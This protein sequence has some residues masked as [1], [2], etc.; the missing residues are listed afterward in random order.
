MPSRRQSNA[1]ALTC[2]PVDE[3]QKLTA[4]LEDWPA[5]RRLIFCDESQVGARVALE[6]GGVGGKWAIL[7]GPEGGFSA[8]ERDRLVSCPFVTQ[9]GLG[10]RI[11]RADTAV[12]AAIALWQSISGDWV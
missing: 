4:I 6:A 7:V 2:P 1:A 8:A 10:P 9:I 12:V 3:L 11:L 5:D